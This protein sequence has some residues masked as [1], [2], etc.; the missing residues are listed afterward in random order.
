M[1]ELVIL[2]HFK[3]SLWNTDDK[4]YIVEQGGAGS[5][6]AVPLDTKV[7]TPDGY[8]LMGDI[9]IGD[10]VCNSYG[11]VSMVTEKWDNPSRKIYKMT[12]KDGRVVKSSDNHKWVYYVD[13]GPLREGTT[14]DIII[15][16]DSGGKIYL[17]TPEPVYFNNT[18]EDVVPFLMGAILGTPKDNIEPLIE[19]IL[20]EDRIKYKIINKRG[21]SAHTIPKEYMRMS[22]YNRI[23][24]VLG[25]FASAGHYSLESQKIIIELESPSTSKKL[26]SIIWSLGG[27]CSLRFSALRMKNILT[28]DFGNRIIKEQILEDYSV[29]GVPIYI[30]KGSRHDIELESIEGAPSERCQCISVDS[31]DSLYLIE[32]YVI[33]HNSAAICQRLSYLFL[34]QENMTFAVVRSTMPALS[35]SVYLGNPSIIRT[36]KDWGIPVNSWLNKTEATIRNPEN[37]SVMYFIGL[38]DPEKIKSMN[39][40]YIFIEE[41]TEIN[42]DKW[43]QLNTRLRSKNKYGKN[44][45]FIAYNPISYYNWVVQMFVAN[46][47]STIKEESKVHFSNFTQNPYVDLE[48]VKSWFSRAAND[49]NY[50]RTYVIGMPGRPLGLIY[51]NISFTPRSVWPKEVWDEAPYYGIDWGFIDPMVLVECRNYKGKIYAVC[52]YYETKKNT[53][54]FLEF[55][56][57]TKVLKSSN[58]YYDSAD[59]ERGSLLLQ[60]GYTGFK[61]KKNIN[62]GISFVNG[63]EIIVDSMGPYGQFAMDEIK[64]Y[65]WKTDSQDS[66]KFIE[67]PIDENN[68]FCDALRYAI[69]TEHMYNRKFSSSTMDMSVEERLR[70][71]GVYSPDVSYSERKKY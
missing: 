71:G 27:E 40:N 45:M 15:A 1:T 8:T 57:N 7:I 61:A 5:G 9:Q 36:L 20:I 67:K 32:E 56:D 11:G 44:Q 31:N 48:D 68:H 47:D 13:E 50:Y 53:R 34:T 46:P 60:R 25:F 51:P 66:S 18:N 29:D 39:L 42:A 4:R 69:V 22:V 49:E 38:D 64:A 2:D 59:A 12:L 33:T 21:R 23:Q 52:R 55:L 24:M 58:I 54:D 14:R 65:T 26:Q 62:A 6:K 43:S 41:A 63:F 37:G 35:R 10:S 17:P 19:N 70:K 28:I 16:I 3:D 30:S